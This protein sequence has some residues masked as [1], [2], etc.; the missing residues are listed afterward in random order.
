MYFDVV[1]LLSLT[2]YYLDLYVL[3]CLLSFA[4]KPGIFIGV[5]SLW[6]TYV[7]LINRDVLW[8]GLLTENLPLT[9]TW[10]ITMWCPCTPVTHDLHTIL[11][12]PCVTPLAHIFILLTKAVSGILPPLLIECLLLYIIVL[13][14]L[15]LAIGK[16]WG[17]ISTFSWNTLF[18]NTGPH[19]RCKNVEV[20]SVALRGFN[21]STNRIV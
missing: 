9:W 15:H 5:V 10:W 6:K 17:E 13:S 12:T 4:W 16:A 20:S 2:T 1:S 18:G 8:C 19:L 14:S 11:C 3:W 7:T 21:S